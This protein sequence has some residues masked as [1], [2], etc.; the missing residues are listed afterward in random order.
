MPRT[1]PPI[2]L[3]SNLPSAWVNRAKTNKKKTN[4]SNIFASQKQITF[5]DNTDEYHFVPPIHMASSSATESNEVTSSIIAID[6][7]QTRTLSASLSTNQGTYANTTTQQQQQT[8]QE[9]QQHFHQKQHHLSDQKNAVSPSSSFSSTKHNVPA[10]T[11]TS[12]SHSHSKVI[13]LAGHEQDTDVVMG[14]LNT[15]FEHHKRSAN[16]FLAPSSQQFESLVMG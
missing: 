14:E 3:P 16:D 11:T 2:L 12:S 13:D 7:M 9:H 5:D 10:V 8:H 1:P 15:V 4:T 6:E